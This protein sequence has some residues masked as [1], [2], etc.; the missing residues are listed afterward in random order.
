LNALDVLLE[1]E[2]KSLYVFNVYIVV[3]VLPSAVTKDFVQYYNNVVLSLTVC[4]QILEFSNAL[5]MLIEGF[6]HFEGTREQ[7]I[8]LC[9]RNE[10]TWINNTRVRLVDGPS[11]LEGRLEVRPTEDD[12]WGT[13]CRNVSRF[14]NVFFQS[15]CVFRIFGPP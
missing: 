13:V 4:G 14:L 9:L 3:L 7:P 8:T 6:V 5:G 12:D 1:R 2:V 15:Q 11:L 10:S